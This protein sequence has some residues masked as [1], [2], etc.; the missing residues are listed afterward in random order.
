MSYFYDLVFNIDV[1]LLVQRTASNLY[2]L[3]V[4]T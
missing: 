1:I 2:R 4:T 3:D